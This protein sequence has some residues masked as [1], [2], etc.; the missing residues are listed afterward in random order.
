MR[1]GALAFLMLT[2][3]IDGSIYLKNPQTGQVV[4]CGGVHGYSYMEGV[5]VTRTAQC[6]QDYKEQGFVRIPGPKNQ[7]ISP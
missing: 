5:E 3:C 7:A 1:V 2:G 6:A 4:K